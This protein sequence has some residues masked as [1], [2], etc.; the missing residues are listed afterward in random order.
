MTKATNALVREYCRAEC[1]TKLAHRASRL[2][3]WGVRV[4]YS[5][6]RRGTGPLTLNNTRPV[7]VSDLYYPGRNFVCTWELVED[8]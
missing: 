8:V 1:D 3:S 6:P 7:I 5:P 4:A 2:R